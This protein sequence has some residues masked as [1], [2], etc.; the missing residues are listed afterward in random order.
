MNCNAPH[1]YDH[2]HFEDGFQPEHIITQFLGNDLT[3]GY[4]KDEK[5]FYITLTEVFDIAH[6]GKLVNEVDLKHSI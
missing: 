6:A 3:F 4:W 1:I 5:F 2:F